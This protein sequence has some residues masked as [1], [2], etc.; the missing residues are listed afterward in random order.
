[1]V[2]QSLKGTAVIVDRKSDNLTDLK[3]SGSRDTCTQVGGNLGRNTEQEANLL[4]DWGGLF[5]DSKTTV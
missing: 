3:S 1:M 4:G 5:R 2:E